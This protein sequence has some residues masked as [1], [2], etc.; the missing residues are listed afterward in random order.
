MQTAITRLLSMKT[1]HATIMWD[2]IVIRIGDKYA[3]G[4]TV[5]IRKAVYTAEQAAQILCGQ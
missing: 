4:E 3:V 5:N 1:G 2:K